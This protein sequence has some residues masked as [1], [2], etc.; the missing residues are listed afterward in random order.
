MKIDLQV[1]STYSDGYLTP[2]QLAVFLAGRG[3]KVASL[4]DYN[5]L[6]G[7][8]E[9]KAACAKRHIKAILGL[10]LYVKVGGRRLNIL[11]YNYQAE[12]VE[13][14]KI[15]LETH[16]RRHRNVRVKLEQL[17][18]LGFHL[19]VE[20]ILSKHPNYIPVNKVA[21]ELFSVPYNQKKIKRELGLK[22]PREED[23]MVEYFFNKQTGKLQDA[24]ISLERIMKLR[25]KVGGQIIFC[26]PGHYNKMRGKI[27]PKLKQMGLDGLELLSPHHNHETIMYI[28][29]LA[30]EF[31]FITTGG[32]DFH[33]FELPDKK[34]K[35]SW[36]WFEINSRYLRKI[37]KIIGK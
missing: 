11:W 10:E 25:K 35:Y 18:K 2:A 8:K 29:Y 9:F 28:Q 7:Q 1:H 26:H 36:Q 23:L 32:S 22:N 34:I 16:L 19:E 30:E 4:T 24:Y 12:S 15:L 27:I 14:Q 37:D 31:N 3:V 20:A 6:A 5:T 17:Q 33:K 21:D 13:L